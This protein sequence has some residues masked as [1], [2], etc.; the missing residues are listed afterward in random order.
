MTE[1]G[2]ETLAP[3]AARKEENVFDIQQGVAILLGV[4][5]PATCHPER[6]EESHCGR[7]SVIL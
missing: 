3:T 1:T 7:I 5:Q 2:Q 6:S 4:K